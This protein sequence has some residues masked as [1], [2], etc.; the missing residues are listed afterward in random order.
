MISSFQVCP[1]LILFLVQ[2][3]V[4]HRTC[5]AYTTNRKF[6][7]YLFERY[8]SLQVTDEEQPYKQ[9]SVVPWVKTQVQ[10]GYQDLAR[11]LGES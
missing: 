8:P 10:G 9:A 5:W 3:D 11:L 6:F 1:A 4:F 7:G 2:F